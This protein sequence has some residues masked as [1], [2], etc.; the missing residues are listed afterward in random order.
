M[1][2]RLNH[3]E[4]AFLVADRERV[5][6]EIFSYEP[7]VAY[8]V[9]ANQVHPVGVTPDVGVTHMQTSWPDVALIVLT[10]LLGVSVLEQ[11]TI[12]NPVVLVFKCAA[13]AFASRKDQ[14]HYHQ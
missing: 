9:F 1:L 2:L 5:R 13:N 11:H 10:H 7:R 6:W 8:R 4:Q 3:V 12:V 14:Y